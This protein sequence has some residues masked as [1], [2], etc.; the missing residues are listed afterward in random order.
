MIRV[1]LLPYY[2]LYED[3]LIYIKTYN[4]YKDIFTTLLKELLSFGLIRI[5]GIN[6]L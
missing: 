4:L 3:S 2:S 5:E 1:T 6:I